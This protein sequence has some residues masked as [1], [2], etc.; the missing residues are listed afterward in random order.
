MASLLLPGAPEADAPR[1]ESINKFD[2][3]TYS[4]NPL[5]NAALAEAVFREENND[6]GRQSSDDAPREHLVSKG[7]VCKAVEMSAHEAQQTVEQ[8]HAM[9]SD[10]QEPSN[11]DVEKYSD[12][13]QN[14]ADLSNAAEFVDQDKDHGATSTHV[15]QQVGP[16]EHMQFHLACRFYPPII[17]SYIY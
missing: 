7:P 16:L 9:D 6:L 13:L 14:L 17:I 15:Q 1:Q 8:A 12:S 3:N 10:A 2:S 4:M 5:A 11:T